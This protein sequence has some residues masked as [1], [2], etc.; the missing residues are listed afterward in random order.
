MPNPTKGFEYA[1]S[2]RL[3]NLLPQTKAIPVSGTGAYAVGDLLVVSSGKLTKAAAGVG[4]VTAVCAQARTTGVDG[5]PLVVQ[6][7]QKDQVWRC[8]ADGASQAGSK[9]GTTKVINIVDENTIDA[10]PATGGSLIL[11]D[12]QGPDSAGNAITYVSFANVTFDQ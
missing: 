6:I 4:E 2:L 11:Y 1:F 10:T 5:D 3:G 9:Y 7:I 12:I 8:S